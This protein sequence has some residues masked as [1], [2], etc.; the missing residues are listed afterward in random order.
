M[1]FSVP[2]DGTDGLEICG[3]IGRRKV[4]LHNNNKLPLALF[5]YSTSHPSFYN[6]NYSPEGGML[7]LF[8]SIANAASSFVTSGASVL[9]V[10]CKR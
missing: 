7:I 3:G 4:W 9:F 2:I 6:Y 5:V 8:S 10:P 1:E